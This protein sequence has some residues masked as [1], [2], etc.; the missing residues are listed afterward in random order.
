[1]ESEAG[2]YDFDLTRFL[3][4]NRHPSSGQARGHASLEK[5]YS[6]L[7]PK[8]KRSRKALR[9]LLHSDKELAPYSG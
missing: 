5:R 7:Q 4:A 9:N 2:L 8:H 1:M 3:H 6:G